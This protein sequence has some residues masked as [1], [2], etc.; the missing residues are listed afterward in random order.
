MPISPHLK[1]LREK[2]GHD[3]IQMPCVSAIVRSK[4]RIL[5][6][7]RADNG[8]WGLPGGAIDPGEH[9]AQA[10]VREV[11]EETGL[12]VRPVRISAVLGGLHIRYPNGDEVDVVT[13][14]FTCEILGGTL[15]ARDG[16]AADLRFFAPTELPPLM[17]AY[18]GGLLGG[19]REEPYFEWRSEWLGNAAPA[20]N[21]GT[22]GTA[23]GHA[24]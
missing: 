12:R 18:P 22:P 8:L 9:P 13:T 17:V 19:D 7:L 10:L 24:R 4:G 2:I 16:E 5:L 6:M 14:V 20:D 21:A 11:F 15:E 3:L 1:R 23:K